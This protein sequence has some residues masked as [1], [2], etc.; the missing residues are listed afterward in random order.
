[1]FIP[2]SRVLKT[3]YLKKRQRISM[4]FNGET[5]RNNLIFLPAYF[6]I[7]WFMRSPKN[8]V[9]IAI[10]KIWQLISFCCVKTHFGKK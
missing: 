1:M 7:M 2:E 6:L 8:F 5:F 9:K 10:L 4:I 3:G